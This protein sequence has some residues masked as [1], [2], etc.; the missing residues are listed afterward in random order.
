VAGWCATAVWGAVRRGLVTSTRRAGQDHTTIE[1]PWRLVFSPVAPID[2]HIAV[3]SHPVLPVT[4]SDVSG[5]WRT[6]I[7]A[8]VAAVD[9]GPA[10]ATPVDSGLGIVATDETLAATADPPFVIPVDRDVRRRVYAEASREPA[11][12]DRLELSPIG[13]T[14]SARG[15]WANYRWEHDAVL[16][17]DMQV[18]TVANGV[19][20]PFGFSAVYSE[21][22][23]RVLEP[24]AGDAAVLRSLFVLTVEEPVRTAPGNAR[25]RRAFPFD[26]VV[27]ETTTYPALL[28]AAWLDHPVPSGG[29][30]P[31]YFRPTGQDG[32]VLFPLRFTAGADVV[33]ATLPLIFVADLSPRFDSLS[34]PG[35]AATLTSVY[36]SV[37]VPVPGISLDLV[38]AATSSVGDRH[39]VHSLS[40]RGGQIDGGY[41]PGVETVGL[42]LPA[43][44]TLLD[45]NKVR[46]FTHADRYL[47]DG[48]GADFVLD[49]RGLRQERGA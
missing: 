3:A 21:P 37:S 5:L 1:L 43:L 42:A 4:A 9:N 38:R 20:F 13:G 26:K 27:V 45:D 18:R 10:A 7:V 2:G 30:L 29:A 46:L 16:G 24:D 19:L 31:T 35:L 41:W 14:M 34:D 22:T 17:R 15:V 39:E 12:V 33:R 25:A 44:R 49:R 8:A 47:D 32:P 11:T 28:R 48:P 40:L 6:R 36:G 23:S